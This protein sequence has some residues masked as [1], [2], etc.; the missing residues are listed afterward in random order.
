MP[1]TMSRRRS[2][3]IIAGM[4]AAAAMPAF[5][6]M[7]EIHR[8]S[9]VALGAEASLALYH[10]DSAQAAAIISACVAELRRLEGILSLYEPGSALCALNR[11]GRLDAPPPELT[12]ILR[13]AKRYGLISGG[14]FDVSVQ[15]L[16]RL[17]FDHFVRPEAD[18]SG[19][20]AA[21]V[22]AMRRTV[23]FRAI[24]VDDDAIRLQRPGMGVTLNGIAQG[25]I[26][27]RIADLLRA[28]GLDNILLD[29]GEQRAL[30]GHADGRPWR[31]GIADPRQPDRI[32]RR[33]DLKDRAMATSGGYGFTFDPQGRFGHIL[34]PESGRSADAWAGVTVTA[35]TATQADALSTAVS[36]APRQ[37]AAAILAAMPG[38]HALCVGWDGSVTEI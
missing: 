18:P 3:S 37:A 6:A 8:W 16:W 25:W 19:P 36:A 10:S 38:C 2:L 17:F 32:L 4:T 5:A 7:P 34:D 27:D 9:G 30:G 33:L 23:D 24:A 14:A 35:P 28:R 29:L 22:E 15:P 26:T 21:L 1:S 31:V 20:P 12:S 13:E 11:R